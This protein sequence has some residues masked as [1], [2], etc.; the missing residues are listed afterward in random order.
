M[1]SAI[2]SSIAFAFAYV[3]FTQ[4]SQ[5][6]S[7]SSPPSSYFIFSHSVEF[8]LISSAEGSTLR[9]VASRLLR[10]EVKIK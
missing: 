3:V 5:F 10:P 4:G 1:C 8:G 7:L 2:P 6:V 9:L